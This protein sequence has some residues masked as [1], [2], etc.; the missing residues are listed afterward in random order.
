MSDRF[1]EHPILNS[2]YEYPTR[3][4]ELDEQGQPTQKI[5]EQRRL[6]KFITPIPR[7]RKRRGAAEQHQIVLDEGIG[8]STA[9]QLYDPTS[10]INEVR[11]HVDRWR[12]IPNREAWKVTPE[13][14]RL[15]QHWR[16]H[17]FSHIRPFF[18]QLE[19]VETAIWLSEVAPHSVK[20]REFLEHLERANLDAN[21]IL[22]RLALKLATGAGKTTVM[23][24]LIAWQT[25]NAVRRPSSKRF[26]RG[27]L[28]VT[29]GITIRDRLRVLQP[30]DPDSY[31]DRRE[32][33]PTDLLP[34][35]SKAKIVITNYHA[36]KRRELFKLSS[37]GRRL[38]QGRGEELNTLESRD[39]CS[40]A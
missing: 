10:I 39:R 21:S 16:H 27:F 28:I 33:V 17:E 38:L 2:P 20:G 24:M 6:A 26:S 25:I 15:L 36:F 37:G 13:T 19:A 7:P 12:T 29:P 32:L 1:F 23:A 11:R 4:W 31:Y 18:C 8:L 9:E 22:K 14:A 35:L 30:H 40:S 3:H 5:V 34:E